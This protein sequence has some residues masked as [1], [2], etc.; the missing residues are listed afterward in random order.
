MKHEYTNYKD[1]SYFSLSC[2]KTITENGEFTRYDCY[3]IIWS[4]N[5]PFTVEIDGVLFNLAQ[6][7]LFF[8]TPLNKIR[9]PQNPESVVVFSFNRE[10]YCIKDNDQEVSCVGYLFFGSSNIQIISLSDD[11]KLK[12][13]NLYNVFLEEFEEKDQILGEMLKVLLKRLIILCTRIA[14]KSLE[15]PEISDRKLDV[16]RQFNLLVEQNYKSIHKVSD[17]ADILNKSPKTLSNLFSLYNK[18]TPLQ[19]I[20]ARRILEAKRL[21]IHSDYTSKEIAFEIGFEDAAHFSRFFKTQTGQNPTDYKKSKLESV[22]GNI[23]K[24]LGN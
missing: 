11:E 22:L 14:R 6:D 17:Y 4:K 7:Q 15:T 20:Q 8:L 5:G 16:I 10:F 24:S 21:L 9:F 18:K 19:T 3:R 1:D 13:D 2:F 23:D 12:L